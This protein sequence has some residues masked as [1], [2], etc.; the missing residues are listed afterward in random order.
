MESAEAQVLRLLMDNLAGDVLRESTL[1]KHADVVLRAGSTLVPVEIKT[2]TRPGTPFDI[3]DVDHVISQARAIERQAEILLPGTTVQPVLLTNMSL[4]QDVLSLLEDA[5]FVVFPYTKDARKAVSELRRHVEQVKCKRQGST[6]LAWTPED[7]DF[8]TA[9]D[10]P[11][12]LF[13]RLASFLGITITDSDN[14]QQVMASIQSAL[15]D[16]TPIDKEL[17]YLKVKRLL[18]EANLDL[19]Y[20]TTV[21]A[22]VEVAEALR[23][24]IEVLRLVLGGPGIETGFAERGAELLRHQ[25]QR[26]RHVEEGLSQLPDTHGQQA[27]DYLRQASTTLDGV[28]KAVD[29]FQSELMMRLGQTNVE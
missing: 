4:S 24:Q 1:R 28:S 18:T 7:L 19:A 3:T 10:T 25:E 13:R 21:A 22:N 9:A 12:E 5:N 8:V 6:R 16:G 2:S 17:L 26:V 20:R 29:E 27:Q 23:K 14:L 11:E 15:F